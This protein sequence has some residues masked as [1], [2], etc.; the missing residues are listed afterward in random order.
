[1]RWAK[2]VPLEFR[3]SQGDFRIT[4]NFPNE[5]VP[6]NNRQRNLHGVSYA[7]KFPRNDF[8]SCL[9]PCSSFAT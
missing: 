6:I 5:A 3:L 9:K 7:V 2:Y 8:V 4:D 1:M